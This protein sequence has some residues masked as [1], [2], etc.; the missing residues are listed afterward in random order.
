[1]VKRRIH[2]VDLLTKR[3]ERSQLKKAFYLA[4]VSLMIAFFLFSFG[5]GVLS[6]F[7]DILNKIFNNEGESTNTNEPA[8]MPILDSLPNATSSAKLKVSGFAFGA[9]KVIFFVNGEKSGEVEVSADKFSFE[10]LTLIDGVNEISAKSLS[11]DQVE[12]DFSKRNDVILDRIAP[13]LIIESP[14]EGQTFSGTNRIS[15]KGKTEKDAQVYAGGFLANVNPEG[16]FE[17]FVPLIEGDNEIEVKTVDVA[18][19]NNSKKIKVRFNR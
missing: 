13:E 5:I 11:P 19:N 2:R 12:S 17:V 10:N 7:A 8:Q 9:D 3:E 6:G 16:N 18:G 1:M 4:V 15:V 14:T